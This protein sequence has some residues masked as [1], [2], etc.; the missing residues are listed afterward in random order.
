MRSQ[1]LYACLIV[2]AACDGTRTGNPIGDDNAMHDAGGAAG[3]AAPN[4][5]NT[6]GLTGEYGGPNCKATPTALESRDADTALGFSAADILAF[7]AGVHETKIRWQSDGIGTFAP[8]TGEHD[9]T[10][11]IEPTSAKPR[12]S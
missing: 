12:A 11:D 5:D 8:E 10:L 3:A 7:A 6:G 9:L 1:L 4:T 2:L